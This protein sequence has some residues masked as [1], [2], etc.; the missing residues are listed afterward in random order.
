[1]LCPQTMTPESTDLS[2]P[3]TSQKARLVVKATSPPLWKESWIRSIPMIGTFLTIVLNASRYETTLE[4]NA[5]F[6][7]GDLEERES[8]WVGKAVGVIDGGMKSA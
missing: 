3:T 1:M 7:A 2:V 5:E 6:I 8:Q 4:Q